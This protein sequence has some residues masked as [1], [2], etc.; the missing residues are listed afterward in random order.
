[1]RH[2]SEHDLR[3]TFSDQ[4]TGSMAQTKTRSRAKVRV[5]AVLLDLFRP[6]G[7][8]PSPL[9]AALQKAAMQAGWLPPSYGQQSQAQK[10]AAGKKSGLTRASLAQ[11]RTQ[12]RRSLLLVMQ[13]VN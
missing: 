8:P 4:G 5:S 7:I 13:R 12:M 6:Y 1:M 2:G 3:I 10:R 11:M 9:H